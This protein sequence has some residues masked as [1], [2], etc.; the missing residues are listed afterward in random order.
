MDSIMNPAGQVF[1]VNNRDV[2]QV[3]NSDHKTVILSY[4]SDLNEFHEIT[5]SIVALCKRVSPIFVK[6]LTLVDF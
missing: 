4:L 3:V 5:S 1:L 6:P 2:F